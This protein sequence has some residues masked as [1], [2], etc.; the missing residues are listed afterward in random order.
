M[1]TR[2]GWLLGAGA[3]AALSGCGFV[4]ARG[5]TP[6]RPRDPGTIAQITG[7]PRIRTYGDLP[8]MPPLSNDPLDRAVLAKIA[9]DRRLDLLAISGGADAGAYGAGFLKGW[10]ARGDRPEFDVVTGV[11]TGALIAPMAYLGPAYDG[12]LEQFYTRTRQDDIYRLRIL[13]VLTGGLS[14]TDNTPLA[15][16]IAEVVTPALVDAL[17]AER[18]K[19]RLLL[20]GTTDLDAQRQ[21]TWDIGRIAASGQPDRVAL[22][23]KVLLASA[24]IPGAFAPVTFAASRDGQTVQELHVDGA[25]TEGVF[26]Y[27]PGLDLPPKSGPR[28][29]WLIRNAKIAPEWDATRADVVGIAGRSVSTLLKAQARSDMSAAKDLAARD[30]FRL[31]MTAVPPNFPIIPEKPFDPAYMQALFDVGLRAGQ[32]GRAWGTLTELSQTGG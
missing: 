6:T 14:A 21:V 27:P 3:A 26:A 30:G 9:S 7:Y 2:R 15:S 29:M 13:D 11:S 18:R 12:A 31:H 16:R 23:R 5:T 32:S 1:L 10:T 17:A 20:I 25:V 28:N 19:G 4:K 24:A 22:I 8:F